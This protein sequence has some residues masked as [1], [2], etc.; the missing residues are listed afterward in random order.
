MKSA[1]KKNVDGFANK[2]CR[3][4]NVVLPPTTSKAHSNAQETKSAYNCSCRKQ[5]PLMNNFAYTTIRL[6]GILGWQS[7][8]EKVPIFPNLW[9]TRFTERPSRYDSHAILDH[10]ADSDL[11]DDSWNS[12]RI[13]IQFSTSRKP[14]T[15]QIERV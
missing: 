8:R 10:Q 14:T 13:K 9:V 4:G 11:I 7:S 2:E 6:F 12:A 5:I 1:V 15:R 3:V